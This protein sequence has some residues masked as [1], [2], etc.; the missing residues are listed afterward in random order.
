VV[1]KEKRLKNEAAPKVDKESVKN[2]H[3]KCRVDDPHLFV[4]ITDKSANDELKENLSQNELLL[5]YDTQ[6]QAFG[7]L[8]TLLRCYNH[9]QCAGK[10]LS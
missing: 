1:A 6:E 9:R 10:N 4:Y 3:E 7:T 5:T 2:E 8:L